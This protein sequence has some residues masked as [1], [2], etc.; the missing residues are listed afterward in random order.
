MLK[1]VIIT[2]YWLKTKGGI[3]TAVYYLSNELKCNGHLTQIL[4]PEGG[5]GATKLPKNLVM[6]TWRMSQ[7]LRG[8]NPDIIHIHAHGS[9]LLGSVIYKILFNKHVRIIFTFH[10]QPH[11]ESFLTGKPAKERSS[12]RRV[13]FNCLLKYCDATTYVSRSLMESLQKVG[14]KTVNPAVIANGVIE[15]TVDSKDI[16]N[17]KQEYNLGE[18]NIILCMTARLEWDSKVKGIEI[19]I[20]AFK[21]VLASRPLAKLLIVGDGQYRKYLEYYAKKE[22]LE[23]KVIFT[24]NMDNPFIALSVCDIYCHISLNEALG[25]APLE[26]MAIGK[27]VIA[28]NDGGLPEIITNGF[29]GILVNS[30]AESVTKAIVCLIENPSFIRKLSE[31][32]IITIKTKFSWERVAR[33][34]IKLYK[35]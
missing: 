5:D 26:A 2:P 8:I 1:I 34:Y 21:D 15:K 24:G 22:G 31:N 7:I 6:M 30:D 25:I 3:T 10:T 11:T 23:K 17:F 4:T 27:P 33:E 14:I 35:K 18:D 29:D 32:A 20:R 13:I 19:L 16:M 28:S 9:L 12:I